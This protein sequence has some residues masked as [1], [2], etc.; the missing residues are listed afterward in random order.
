MAAGDRLEG[1]LTLPR[2]ADWLPQRERLAA[3]EVLDLSAVTH[4]DSAGLALLLE[5]RRT[6]RARGR[7]LSF[8]GAPPQLRQLTE[9]FGLTSAL[10]L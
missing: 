5:L 2:M 6:A 1:Q 8:T 4:A 7:I 3:A 9:F 10:S